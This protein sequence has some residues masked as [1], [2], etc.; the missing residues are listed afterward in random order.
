MSR[1]IVRLFGA[2]LG[3]LTVLACAPAAT[4]APPQREV[5]HDAFSGDIS[6]VT[7]T[8]SVTSPGLDVHN[9]GL[10]NPG[11]VRSRVVVDTHGTPSDPDDDV[12]LSF[13]QIKGSTGR[14]DD[15]CA[16]VVPALT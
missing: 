14:T 15:F 1:I 2:A 13:E 12:E 10:G 6:R 3:V 11:Q 8:T 5:I 7:S 4:A 9:E 16:D